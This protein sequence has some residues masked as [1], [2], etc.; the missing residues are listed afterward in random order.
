[1]AAYSRLKPIKINT[2][3]FTNAQINTCRS[4]SNMVKTIFI[5]LLFTYI[6]IPIFKLHF[7]EQY[8]LQYKTIQNGVSSDH[9][10]AM[11]SSSPYGHK[12]HHCRLYYL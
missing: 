7:I 5:S 3:R 8:N 2:D 6:L 12:K 11:Y 1:M 10:G 9:I 4:S